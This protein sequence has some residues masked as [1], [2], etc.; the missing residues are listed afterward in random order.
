MHRLVMVRIL[1]GGGG[2]DAASWICI[3]KETVP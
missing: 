2:N 1:W 3:R